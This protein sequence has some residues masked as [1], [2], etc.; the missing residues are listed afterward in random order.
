MKM[1]E[2]RKKKRK[3]LNAKKELWNSLF[4]VE[5]MLRKKSLIIIAN[6]P[7]FCVVL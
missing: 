6:E 5:N 7:G 3:M 1:D 4:K 2:K